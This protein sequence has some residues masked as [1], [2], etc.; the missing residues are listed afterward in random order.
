M[1]SYLTH[2][3]Q[4]WASQSDLIF[5]RVYGTDAAH[6]NI[7]FTRGDHG[8]GSVFDGKGGTLAHAF[9]PRGG[10]AHFDEDETWSIDGSFGL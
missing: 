9:Y 1:K 8:D 6:I 5:S 4:M 7:K 3:H 10:D 2:T